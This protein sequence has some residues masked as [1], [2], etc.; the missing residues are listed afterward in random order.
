[1][2]FPDDEQVKTHAKKKRGGGGGVKD[3]VRINAHLHSDRS[4]IK[5]FGF[6]DLSQTSSSDGFIVKYFKNL[7]WGF[8]EILLEESVHLS[9]RQTILRNLPLSSLVEPRSSFV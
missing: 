1:M 8:V 7:L 3:G 9:E 2:P 5:Q 6:M 4:A